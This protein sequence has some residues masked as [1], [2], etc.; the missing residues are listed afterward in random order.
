MQTRTD[1]AAFEMF[2]SFLPAYVDPLVIPYLNASFP[3]WWVNAD[4]EA[5]VKQLATTTEPKERIAV[6][7]ELHALI[8][9]QAPFMKYGTES[10]LSAV[11]KGTVGVS[12]SPA[13]TAW[14]GNIAPLPAKWSAV[15]ERQ[16]FS[17]RL[18]RHTTALAAIGGLA[19]LPLLS[20]GA[21][22]LAGPKSLEIDPL[23]RLMPPSAEHWFGTDHLGRDMLGLVLFGGRTS[24]RV[25]VVVSVLA[26]GIAIVLGLLPGFFRRLDAVLMRVVDGVMS[27][28]GIVLATAAAGYL[29]PSINTVILALTLVLIAP[30]LRVVR[31]QVLVVREL[32]MIE[33]ARAVGVPT[34]RLLRRYILPAVLS[35]LLVQASFVF[36]AAVLGEAGLSLIGL[37]IGA[38]DVSW[39]SA[40]AEARNYIQ[41]AWWIVVFPGLA[42]VLTILALNLLGDA[43]RDPLDPKLRRRQMGRYLLRR[44]GYML[45]TIVVPMVLVFLLLRLSPGDPAAMSLGDQATTTQIAA[46]RHEMGL[47]RALP[48]QFANWAGHVLT[49]QLGESLFFH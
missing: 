3:G 48:I 15:A 31:G 33:A 16:T 49:L 34:P 38:R 26:M 4:K 19:V 25:G 17:Q 14:V 29:G 22:L 8:C 11:R 42:L 45:P 20:L 28:P 2:S 47:D 21:G 24:L 37:G 10:L 23:N 36:S 27:F 9:Q 35:P 12:S 6:W 32:P 39:G 7:N 41:D 30:A 44:L 46:L 5:L 40:L 1:P 43:L 18:R 13:N